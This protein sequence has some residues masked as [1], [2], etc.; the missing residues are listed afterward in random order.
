MRR[1]RAGD[2]RRTPGPGECRECRTLSG[3]ESCRVRR[4]PEE[5]VPPQAGGP[6]G[7]P[8][9]SLSLARRSEN[10]HY[11]VGEIRSS[12]GRHECTGYVPPRH[13]R[14]SL[15][16]DDRGRPAASH[17]LAQGTF[18]AEVTPVTSPRPLGAYHQ[19]NMKKMALLAAFLLISPGVFGQA[20]TIG[21]TYGGSPNASDSAI[22]PTRTDVSLQPASANG[23]IDTV[24]VYWSST[25][26]TNALKI[27]FFHRIGN[28]LTLTAER[29]A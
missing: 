21:T 19:S 4:L 9:V 24:H 22:S 1:L 20:L 15:R 5:N 23:T 3:I 17:R 26:C 13:S 28:T 25:G 2:R 27:K 10:L 6:A 12:T 14:R 16:F 18:N 11:G 29:G 8:F 7:L